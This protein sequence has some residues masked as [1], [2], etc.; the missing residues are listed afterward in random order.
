MS[1]EYLLGRSE[2]STG[3]QEHNIFDNIHLPPQRE[4]EVGPSFNPPW[5]F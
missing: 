2:A 5:A 4:V 1:T 3:I